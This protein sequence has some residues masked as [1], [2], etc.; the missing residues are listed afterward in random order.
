MKKIAI[1]IMDTEATEIII[2]V[3]VVILQWKILVIAKLNELFIK[4]K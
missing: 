1:E 3:V 4:C 2:V